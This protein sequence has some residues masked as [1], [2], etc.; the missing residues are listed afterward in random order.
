MFVFFLFVI[1]C[2]GDLLSQI[3][4]IL[5]SW[6]HPLTNNHA[7]TGVYSDEAFH[8]GILSVSS[9]KLTNSISSPSGASGITINDIFENTRIDENFGIKI[10][11]NLYFLTYHKNFIFKNQ[12]KITGGVQFQKLERNSPLIQNPTHIGFSTIYHRALRASSGNERYLSFG[13]KLNLVPRIPNRAITH[14]AYYNLL[15]VPPAISY[16]EYQNQF[17]NTGSEQSVS[18]NYSFLKKAKWYFG[19]T[20][21][22]SHFQYSTV[23][24]RSR[25]TTGVYAFANTTDYKESIHLNSQ[26]QLGRKAILYSNVLISRDDQYSLGIGFRI[27]KKNILKIDMTRLPWPQITYYNISFETLKYKYILSLGSFTD[28]ENSN[29]LQ[30]SIRYSINNRNTKSLISLN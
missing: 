23:R 18:I 9:P 1:L 13:F 27:R 24:N 21:S 11:K 19:A 26:I 8:M 29:L 2:N 28:Q 4:I 14:Y 6:D 12:D 17:K 16:R 10:V 3:P 15:V 30:M 25:S 20:L 5:S 22:L 7:A